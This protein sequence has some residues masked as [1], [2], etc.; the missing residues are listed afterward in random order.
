[1]LPQQ[2]DHEEFVVRLKEV[3]PDKQQLLRDLQ[4][5]A[6]R[7]FDLQVGL[8]GSIGCHTSAHARLL[9]PVLVCLHCQVCL[10]GLSYAVNVLLQWLRSIHQ[11]VCHTLVCASYAAVL[12]CVMCAG[13]Q[14]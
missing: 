4:D 2:R 3:V 11:S 10:P 5:N 7:H 8:T 1:M 14:S 6:A 13:G 12:I 9:C